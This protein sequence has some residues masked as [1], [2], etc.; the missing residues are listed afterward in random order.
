MARHARTAHIASTKRP[1]VWNR[2]ATHQRP[3]R[4][5]DVRRSRVAR[6]SAPGLRVRDSVRSTACVSGMERRSDKLPATGLAMGSGVL[7]QF[8]DRESGRERV[9][10]HTRLARLSRLAHGWSRFALVEAPDGGWP[11]VDRGLVRRVVVRR[12]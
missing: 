12:R 9:A 6:H 10:A 4:A 11:L 5:R 2:N 8:A 3:F 1:L 7:A